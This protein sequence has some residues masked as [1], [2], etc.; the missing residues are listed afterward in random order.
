MRSIRASSRSSS[1]RRA[2]GATNSIS[3]RSASAGPRQRASASR[4]RTTPAAWLPAATA[5]RPWSRRRSN[6]RRVELIGLDREH[7]AAGAGQQQGLVAAA[8]RP[9]QRARPRRAPRWRTGRL[10][11]EQVLDQPLGRHQRVGVSPSARAARAG[12][13][14]RAGPARR[15]APPPAARARGTASRGA[16]QS[17]SHRLSDA[18][19][20]R[21]IRFGQAS[22]ARPS[23]RRY[24]QPP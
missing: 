15:R 20:R 13:L 11:A 1:R 8:Q 9:A 17:P 3:A 22:G 4:N 7:V 24:T 19:R 23:R 10:A 6:R 18:V 14:R 16:P 5:C 21:A 2:S 12:V